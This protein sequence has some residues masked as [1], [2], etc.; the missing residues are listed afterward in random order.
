MLRRVTI[1]KLAPTGEGVARSAEGVG[2]V[3]GAL[4]GEEIDAEI[5]TSKKRFWFG[6]AVSV[7][8][9]SPRR[10]GGPHAGC[11]GCDWSHFELEA[12]RE[13]KRELF[14]QTMARIGDLAPHLFGELP[15][16]ASPAAYRIRSRFHVSGLG[17]DA[18]VGFHAPGSNRVEPAHNC[19][20]LTGELRGALPAVREAVAAGGL[21]VLEIAT[22]ETPDA[23]RRMAAVRLCEEP[24]GF[25][26]AGLARR[27]GSLFEGVRVIGRR[28]RVLASEGAARLA[29]PVE[30]RVFEVS[31]ESFF[32]VNRHLAPRLYA[33]VRALAAQVGPGR[34]LDAYGGVG[35]FAG[36]LLEAGHRVVSV[37]A[38]QA[39]AADAARS[40]RSW[41]AKDS[42]QIVSAPVGRFL[43]EKRGS[44]DL[45]VADPPRAGL[46]LQLAGLLAARAGS[47]LI[48][49]SCD[50]ATLARDLPVILGAGFSIASASLYDLFAFTHRVEAVVVLDRKK[51]A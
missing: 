10:A 36:A 17:P 48:Y 39:A 19:E 47:R 8:A 6:R 3:G 26:A 43:G 5:T 18:A 33:D 20:A 2:F 4:P 41:G 40:R 11:A 21:A 14:L 23:A 12:A 31:P 50:P 34:A 25:G 7:L 28:G 29:L 24:E 32:Q 44:F 42:W 46:G 16:V 30:G 15:L 38:S 9:G 35:F 22:L 45:A 27:L 51:P 49:V 13:A 37:E 1:E